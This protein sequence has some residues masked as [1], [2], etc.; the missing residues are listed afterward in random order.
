M[1][2]FL[3]KK[4]I[5]NITSSVIEGT[6]SGGMDTDDATLTSGDQMLEGITAYSKGN[7]IT[8]TIK[9]IEPSNPTISI[10]D[11]G[12]ITANVENSKGYQSTATTKTATNQLTTQEAKTIT[13]S[14]AEQVAVGKNV[15][16]T[17][18]VIVSSVPTETKA[19]TENGNY[20]PS[21]GKYFS[22]VSVNVPNNIIL[23]SKS[24][25]PMEASQTVTADSSYNGLSEVN[26]GAVSST[27]VGSAVPT[28]AGKIITPT[29]ESLVAVSSGTYTTGN[30]TVEAIPDQYIDTSA[31]T[32]TAKDL[33]EGKTAYANQN[34]LIGTLVVNTYYTGSSEP[35]SSLGEDG[36]IY[37]MTEEA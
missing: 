18:Q 26:I 20:S 7:K 9:T 5:A 30:V 23:Q 14:N 34:Q 35:S 28:Q 22:S 36:D 32:A 19:I 10:S 37:L 29:K 31:A 2:I 17:G 4:H 16:T 25:T 15:Y 12:L 11:N 27:Y 33:V 6:S 24:V 3:G 21:S 13:P 8:G 1:P